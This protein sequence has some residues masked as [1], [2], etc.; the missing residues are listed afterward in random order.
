MSKQ[1][2]KT[3]IISTKCKFKSFNWSFQR[4]NGLF[5][6]ATEDDDQRISDKRYYFPNV[7]I[8]DYNVMN[9]GK[10]FFDQP[11]KMIK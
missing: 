6:L 4:V 8:K 3:C 5:V 10:N 7:E 1:Y 11:V 2:V 9:D